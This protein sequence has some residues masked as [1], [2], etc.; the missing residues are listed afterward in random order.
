VSLARP[1]NELDALQ[2]E[3]KAKYSKFP[4][5]RDM[6]ISERSRYVDPLIKIKRRAAGS[7]N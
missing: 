5:V 4:L 1:V 6:M 3:V 7:R 2:A